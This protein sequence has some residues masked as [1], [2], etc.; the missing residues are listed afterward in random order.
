MN[1]RLNFKVGRLCVTLLSLDSVMSTPAI[2][3]TTTP[4]GP[5]LFANPTSASPVTAAMRPRISLPGSTVAE[6][7]PVAS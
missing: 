1:L 7:L 2:A 5:S 3:N 6:G 4:N